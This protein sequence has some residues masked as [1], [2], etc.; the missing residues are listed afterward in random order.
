MAVPESEDGWP[1]PEAF[2]NDD[3]S[4]LSLGSSVVRNVLRLVDFLPVFYLVGIVSLVF[5]DANQRLGDRFGGTV[6]VR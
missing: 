3:G 4:P 2:V 5:S 6:V 1:T